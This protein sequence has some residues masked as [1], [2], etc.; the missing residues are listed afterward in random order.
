MISLFAALGLFQLLLGLQG[1]VVLIRYRAMIPFM[2]LS[3]LILQLSS[4]V[5]RL[6]HPIATPDGHPVGYYV[7]LAIL[8]MTLIGLV[9]SLV[10]KSDSPGRTL[11][12]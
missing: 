9:L 1:V 4:R 12:H 3:F 8:A 11:E 5:I 2:Y 6:A 7:N 10:N